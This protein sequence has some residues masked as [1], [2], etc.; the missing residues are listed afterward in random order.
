MMSP[1]VSRIPGYAEAWQAGIQAA[2][3]R[4]D[5]WWLDEVAQAILDVAAPIIEARVVAALVDA[6]IAGEA[7]LARHEE[8]E[9]YR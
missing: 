8:E 1:D 7:A 2:G 4:F 5:A 9:L 6:Q 3:R